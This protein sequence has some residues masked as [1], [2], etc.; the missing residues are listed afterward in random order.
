MKIE[1]KEESKQA[2]VKYP[3]LMQASNGNI[4]MFLDNI[5]CICVQHI[6]GNFKEWITTYT[7]VQIDR[8]TPFKGSITLSND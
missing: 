6:G 3:C 2:E 7:S 5:S 4:F 8:L 1:V